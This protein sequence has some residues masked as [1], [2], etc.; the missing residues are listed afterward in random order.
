MI[1]EFVNNDLDKVMNI[2]LE[3]NIE[4][5]YF[6]DVNYWKDNFE[7][8]KDII[9]KATLYVYEVDNVILGFIGLTDK[10]ISG[11]FVKRKYQSRGIGKSLLDYTK[12]KN[13]ELSL[14][15]YKNNS[16]AVEFYSREGFYIINETIDNSTG[17]IEIN[18]KWNKNI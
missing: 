10:Y 8:V 9:P 18:M 2:W 7:I 4:T 1:R 15:V 3:T 16:R 6:V 14:S 11:I 17:Q 5:H 12:N 13:D